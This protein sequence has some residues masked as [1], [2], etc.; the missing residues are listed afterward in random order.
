MLNVVIV[1]AGSG[2]AP[3]HYAAFS[4]VEGVKVVGAVDI[5]PAVREQVATQ[6]GVPAYESVAELRERSRQV[7]LAVICV[8]DDLHAEVASA[9][10]DA[11]WHT[12]IEKPMT[13]SRSESALL[14]RQAERRGVYVGVGLQRRYMTAGIAELA[15]GGAIGKITQVHAYWRRLDAG[16]AWRAGLD[17]RGGV[18]ADLGVHLLSQGDDLRRTATPVQVTARAWWPPVHGSEYAGMVV[19]DYDDGGSLAVNAEYGRA[20]KTGTDESRLEVVGSRG[21]I[22]AR[23]LTQEGRCAARRH[24][25]VLRLSDTCARRVRHLRR[26]PTVP[27][28]HLLLAR[29]VVQA[30]RNG[31]PASADDVQREIRLMGI[32]DGAY[33]SLKNGGA[34][35]KL[36]HG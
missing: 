25:P 13:T 2:V 3:D 28:C 6:W 11:G 8:R 10:L 36:G 4:T 26:L 7:H 29:H 15:H 32:L 20:T 30:V 33:E 9:T 23:L 16:P 31:E 34:P 21:D 27:E 14:F 19:V 5:V 22:D 35:V 18:L 1:G 24:R 12:L 17:S